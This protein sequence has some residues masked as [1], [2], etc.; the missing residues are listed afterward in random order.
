LDSLPKGPRGEGAL[1]DDLTD[2]LARVTRP[3]RYV[4]GEFNLRRKT[5]GRP[6]VVL[7]YPDVYEI[8]VVNPGLQILYSALNDTTAAVAERA[9]CPWPDMATLMRARG[10]PLWTLESYAPVRECDLWGLTLQHELT[11]TNVL[12]MLD[13]AGVPL[14]GAQRGEGDPIV[15]AGGP[16][17]ANPLPMA[18]FFDAFFVGEAEGRLG[19]LVEA[20]GAR[21]RPPRLHQLARIP[22]VWLPSRPHDRVERQVF[23]GF[24]RSTPVDEPLVPLI[25]A[26]HDRVTVEVM[27]GCTAGCRF[28]Q[29]GMWYRPVRERPVETVVAAATRALRR[30]GC[31][32][33]SLVSLSSCDYS[34]IEAAIRGIREQAPGV[35]VSLPSLRV[36]SA[37]VVLGRLED[38]QRGTVTLAPEAGTQGLRDAI[39]KHIGDDDLDEAVRAVFAA[40]F[41]GLKLYFMIGLP[42]ETDDDVRAIADLA[43]AARRRAR[44][45]AA[46]RAAVRV[47]VSS[48]VPKPQTPFERERFA[49]EATI[50]SRQDLLRVA[51]PHGVRASF[52]DVGA[53]LVE[54]TLAT[55]GAPAAALVE[56][57]W[58]AGAR[59][60]GWGEGFDRDAWE[61]AASETG[62]EL[63]EGG[64]GSGALPWDVVDGGVEREFLAR[65]RDRARTGTTTADCRSGV[66]DSCGV[67]REGVEMELAV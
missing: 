56:A 31:D 47:S 53:S 45:V 20:R 36:D 15:V 37:A 23:A 3:G 17:T 52:H 65:E 40:G 62:A 60:D 1:P 4:G 42:G 49:G 18:P 22:G 55:G 19:E 51:L 16:G 26:V 41:S 48:F 6:R 38:E 10:M 46:G 14:H 33:V 27:R 30:T 64:Q 57:A 7:S 43:G 13:L 58:R 34:G 66:C 61:R 25:E 59:F 9:Y 35:R 12:E 54:A 5:D 28:C 50:R 39:N 21:G 32:E 11:Y 67:C 2:L 63:G 44:E 24:A 8:G 29:A